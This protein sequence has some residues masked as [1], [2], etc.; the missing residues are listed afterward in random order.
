MATEKNSEP[1]I[2]TW[3]VILFTLVL[4]S[5]ISVATLYKQFLEGQN[6]LTLQFK[7]QIHE[8]RQKYLD[9]AVRPTQQT[10]EQERILRFLSKI[11]DDTI[12]SHWANEE[13]AI[14]QEVNNEKRKK[15]SLSLTEIKDSATNAIVN[16]KIDS[17]N[18]LIKLK[19]VSAGIAPERKFLKLIDAGIGPESM[20]CKFNSTKSKN[21][22][23][24]LNKECVDSE[25]NRNRIWRAWDE[26]KKWTWIANYAP[27]MSDLKFE[28]IEIFDENRSGIVCECEK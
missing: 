10:F 12:L 9:L 7:N 24:A 26:G 14:V 18:R 3:W 28:D 15:D 23:K 22:N 1:K 13:L 20:V 4:P 2:K 16:G 8:T 25:K 27:L 11:N 19:S 17:L 21:E 5:I 6:N